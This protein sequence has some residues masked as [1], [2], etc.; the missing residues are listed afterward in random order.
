MK[1]LLFLLLFVLSIFSIS[2]KKKEERK[3]IL[4][5]A[6]FYDVQTLDPRKSGDYSS[7]QPI[8]MIWPKHLSIFSSTATKPSITSAM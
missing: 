3:K 1:K 2:C 7:S 5:T 4:K 6:F 8:F